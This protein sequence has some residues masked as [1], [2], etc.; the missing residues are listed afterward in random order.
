MGWGHF[1]ETC[2]GMCLQS[3]MLDSGCGVCRFAERF[4]TVPAQV[5][6][7]VG[8]SDRVRMQCG[9]SW[10]NGKTA[11]CAFGRILV[12]RLR[13]FQHA[14]RLCD[15]I[16]VPDSVPVVGGG[17]AGSLLCDSSDDSACGGGRVFSFEK[18]VSRACG[19]AGGVAEVRVL[20]AENVRDYFVRRTFVLLDI[21]RR[22]SALSLSQTPVVVQRQ[23]PLLKLP[24]IF[25]L[26]AAPSCNQIDG[27][28]D[29][30]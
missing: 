19:C 5:R 12:F 11:A 17:G 21:L 26:L 20:L 14:C 8:R 10:Q 2:R 25:K 15:Q 9:L 28:L 29:F 7:C 6:T 30:E 27:F 18:V 1:L 3:F 23:E 13:L 16:H 24:V 22:E 4:Q